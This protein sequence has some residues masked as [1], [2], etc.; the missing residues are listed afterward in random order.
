M[1]AIDDFNQSESSNIKKQEF[2]IF[3]KEQYSQLTQME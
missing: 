1:I 3:S 2:K